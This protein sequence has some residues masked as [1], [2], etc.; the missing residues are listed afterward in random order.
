[1]HTKVV[2]F[3]IRVSPAFSFSSNL[4]QVAGV[5]ARFEEKMRGV[6]EYMQ[7]RELPDYLKRKVY[8]SKQSV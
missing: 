6:V 8:T 4:L 2:T 3:L 1:V 7:F 5:D